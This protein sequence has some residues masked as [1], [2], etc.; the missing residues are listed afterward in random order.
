MYRIKY[1]NEIHS[2]LDKY[3][4][5]YKNMYNNMYYIICTIYTIILYKNNSYTIQC[6]L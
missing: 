3:M 1:T 6:Y 4:N 2:Q 5:L